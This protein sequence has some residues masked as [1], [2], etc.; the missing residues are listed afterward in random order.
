MVIIQVIFL[1]HYTELIDFYICNVLIIMVVLLVL[2]FKS[3]SGVGFFRLAS[4]S[5]GITQLF[6]SL[7]ALRNDKC[8]QT[9]LPPAALP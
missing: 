6:P 5:F 2:T 1:K 9:Y 4:V 3:L 8:L 7:F